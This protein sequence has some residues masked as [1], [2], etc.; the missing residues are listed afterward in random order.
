MIAK[1]KVIN[2]AL[3]VTVQELMNKQMTSGLSHY[4]N[5]VL[6]QR[7]YIL[8]YNTT[9]YITSTLVLE[10][11]STILNRLLIPPLLDAAKVYIN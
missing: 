5:C 3:P 9:N 7:I 10:Q 6:G 4:I 2:G 1:K 8:G 11:L